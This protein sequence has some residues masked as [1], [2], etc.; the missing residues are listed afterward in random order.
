M[1][2]QPVRLW[3]DP[4]LQ[5]VAA[6]VTDPAAVQS[7]IAD[8]FDTMYAAPGRGL[9]A[10]QI[11]VLARVFVMDAGWRTG[12]HTPRV[13]LNP[14]ILSA[15]ETLES[16]EEACLSVPGVST[17]VTRPEQIVL[18]YADATGATQ[19]EELNGAE[20][21]IAQHELDHLDGTM[22]FDRIAAPDRAALLKD[23]GIHP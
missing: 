4:V 12:A 22:H 9:A 10:P 5:E 11:G 13:C 6:P 18:E 3:P 21:R 15:S 19:V 1:P 23:Y 20:A 2:V 16:G 14:R 7:L 17:A 8:L